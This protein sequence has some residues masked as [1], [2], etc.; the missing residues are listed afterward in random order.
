MHS[1]EDEPQKSDTPMASPTFS[2]QVSTSVKSTRSTSSAGARVRHGAPGLIRR[3]SSG[4]AGAVGRRGAGFKQG[5]AKGRGGSE[6]SRSRSRDGAGSRAAGALA[7]TMGMTTVTAAGSGV[8]KKRGGKAGGKRVALARNPSRGAGFTGGAALKRTLSHEEVEEVTDEGD[9]DDEEE[10]VAKGA[11]IRKAEQA[12]AAARLEREREIAAAVAAKEAAAAV[13]QQERDQRDRAVAG[14]S[15]AKFKF[16]SNSDNG[17]AAGTEVSSRQ[18]GSLLQTIPSALDNMASSRADV[19]GKGR[20]PTSSA[21]EAEQTQARRT[22]EAVVEPARN[23][24]EV[25]GVVRQ[26]TTGQRMRDEDAQAEVSGSLPDPMLPQQGAKRTILLESDSEYSD[27]DGD[28]DESWMSE[29]GPAVETTAGQSSSN[30]RQPSQP[31]KRTPQQPQT[32]E[33]A[34]FQREQ[35]QL[36]QQ[37][38]LQL[39]LQQ[40]EQRTTAGG[41]QRTYSNVSGRHTRRELQHIQQRREAALRVQRAAALLQRQEE[42][43]QRQKEMFAKKATSSFQNLTEKNRTQSFGYLSQLM[44]PDPAIFPANHPYRRGYSSGELP[45]LGMSTITPMTSTTAGAQRQAAQPGPP[46]RSE[47]PPA[48]RPNVE[49]QM[50]PDVNRT[51]QQAHQQPHRPQQPTPPRAPRRAVTQDDSKVMPAPALPSPN[52][53]AQQK[54]ALTRPPS[55]VKNEKR[56]SASS[57]AI[58]LALRGLR[59]L[60][61]GL[62]KSGAVGPLATQVAVGSVQTSAAAVP[63]PSNPPDNQKGSRTGT[64]GYRP[65][66]PLPGQEMESDSEDEVE[67]GVQLSHSIAQDRLKQFA[68]RRG[69]AP[70]AGEMPAPQ[71]GDEIPAWAREPERPTQQPPQE[72]TPLARANPARPEGLRVTTVDVQTPPAPIPMHPYH[73]PVNAL[74]STPR[75]V[76][77]AMLKNEMPESL[78]RQLLWERKQAAPIR[79]TSSSGVVGGGPARN[80]ALTG[81]RPLTTTPN[82]S[83]VQLHAKGAGNQSQQH[84]NPGPSHMRQESAQKGPTRGDRRA[85]SGKTEQV[86]GERDGDTSRSMPRSYDGYHRAGW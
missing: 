28:G 69:I 7:A 46:Q 67:N 34:R 52:G 57:T 25:S 66:G 86:P 59:G 62:S 14:A 44:N 58:A 70:A 53:E 56:N 63:P 18:P 49:K 68:A 83:M 13:I 11:A 35:Q 26:S 19:K 16:G 78:R 71:E 76:R 2:P 81:L 84:L 50:E 41:L 65:K 23:V 32:P 4:A 12:E 51:P 10:E 82:K 30:A 3:A 17:S 79:R 20:S 1:D 75:T 42:E 31:E 64:G 29:D 85:S 73:L 74:P 38:Q 61:F 43:R 39:Q 37:L 72:T 24:A 40:A 60:G 9:F 15:K 27:T 45:S 33:Q 6:A 77:R 22:R 21:Q 47:Q 48:P 80:N 36:Q 8:A 55:P 5:M 54:R